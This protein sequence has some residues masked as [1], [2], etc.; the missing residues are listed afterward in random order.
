ME[1]REYLSDNE[2]LNDFIVEDETNGVYLEKR[3][4]GVPVGTKR[5]QAV[6]T[7]HP[8]FQSGSTSLK[9][10]RRYLGMLLL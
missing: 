10:E 3:P 8:S 6:K 4:A 5:M 7:L 1:A 2:S 9:D